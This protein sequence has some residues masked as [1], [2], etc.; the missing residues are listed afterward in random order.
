MNAY[1]YRV[2]KVIDAPKDA[3]WSAWTERDGFEKLFH[4]KPGSVSL[5]VRP[6]GAW[7]VTMIAPDGSEV[8]MSGRYG[9]VEPGRRLVTQMD[10]PGRAE[11]SAMEL[12]LIDAGAGRTEVA[13][14]QVCDSQEEHDFAKE[15]SEVLLQWC[16]DAVRSA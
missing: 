13:L 4:A 15:G 1:A 5:D 8:P 10:A 6:G 16:A 3:V 7:Q 12:E 2:T 9:D 14:S 11:P